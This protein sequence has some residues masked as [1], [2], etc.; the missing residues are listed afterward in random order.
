MSKPKKTSQ[1][2][3]SAADKA[4]AILGWLDS[5]DDKRVPLR[6]ADQAAL[7]KSQWWQQFKAGERSAT[8]AVFDKLAAQGIVIH[9]QTKSPCHML[10]GD[11]GPNG[12][13][14]RNS[15]P[16]PPQLVSSPLNLK[17]W[18]QDHRMIRQ[19]YK[20]YLKKTGL[21]TQYE[22]P[23]SVNT[24]LNRGIIKPAP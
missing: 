3:L 19:L 1:P 16:L 2:R 9:K 13:T 24:L 17:K 10:D 20:L 15:Q 14:V 22:L 18:R 5:Y 7:G 11:E 8:K 23:V 4:E 6:V 12:F 21:G